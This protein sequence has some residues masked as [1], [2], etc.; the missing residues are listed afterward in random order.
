[1][2]LAGEI[3]SNL[4][5]H[6]RT[7]RLIVTQDAWDAAW[8]G[9]LRR[10][11]PWGVGHVT[12][13]GG[14]T[15][16]ELLVR[17]IQLTAETPEGRRWPPLS[18]W[19]V[20]RL[21]GQG[22]GDFFDSLDQ[23]ATRIAPARNQTLILFAL[24]ARHPERW[25]GAVFHGGRCDGLDEVHVVGPGMLLLKRRYPDWDQDGTGASLRA[26]RTV[27]AVGAAVHGRLRHATVTLVGA[28]RNGSAAA[29]QLAGLGVRRLRI[30]DPDIL[31]LENLDAMPGLTMRDVGQPKGRA[32][33]RR[34]RQFRPDL[35]ISVLDRAIQDR[36]SAAVLRE[37]SDLLITAVDDD[38]PRLAAA[39]I[40]AQ[41]LTVHVDIGT[42]IQRGADGPAVLAGDARLFLP[43][44][45]CAACVGGFG[46][47]AETLYELNSPQGSL[48]RRPP[49]DWRQQRAGSLVSLNSL[50]VSAA[51]QLWLD[52]LAGTLR[53][54]FWQ[55]VA[56]EAG[57]GLVSHA[58]PVQA[59]R[60]CRFCQRL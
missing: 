31:G 60:D 8:R 28:G 19:L 37:R 25:Q 47:P 29:F 36:R 20:M 14:A 35:A 23:V 30:I 55:R 45:G 6:D 32:L 50:T 21:L 59:A 40:A 43:G 54:S 49:L 48:R 18:D 7:W 57:R 3:E 33:A 15:C 39:V 53:S 1:M 13:Q 16:R 5:T 52:L 10:S 2:S 42:R 26:S 38:L 51:V 4:P 17:R 41:T 22:D 44:L 12:P 58:G 11:D 27:G 34:L 9:L 24:D 46:D 56:W